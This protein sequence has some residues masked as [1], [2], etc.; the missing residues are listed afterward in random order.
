MFV[1][2]RAQHNKITFCSCGTMAAVPITGC[3]PHCACAPQGCRAVPIAILTLPCM[4][5]TNQCMQITIVN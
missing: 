3:M 2:K 1:R 5:L 4:T